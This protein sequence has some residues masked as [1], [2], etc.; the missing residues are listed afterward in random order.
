LQVFKGDLNMFLMFK[1]RKQVNQDII[2]IRGYK[3]I[4][5]FIKCVVN[6]LLKY[7]KTILHTEW[8]Y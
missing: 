7:T 6:I 1:E 3:Y 5:E 4:K 8:H 2:N